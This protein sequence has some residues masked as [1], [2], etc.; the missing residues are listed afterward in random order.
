MKFTLQMG[1]ELQD[2]ERR[3]IAERDAMLRCHQLEF[4]E[5]QERQFREVAAI[6]LLPWIARMALQKACKK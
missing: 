5:M 2:T 6:P 3:H 1:R 4:L